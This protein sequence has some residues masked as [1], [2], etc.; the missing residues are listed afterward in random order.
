M[1]EH[2]FK[3]IILKILGKFIE[4]FDYNELKV[5][6]WNGHVT[7]HH[8]SLKPEALRF[9]SLASG[10][11][12]TVVK[13]V[14]GRLYLNLNWARLWSE[15]ITLTLEDV[16]LVVCPCSEFDA[17][18][19][20]DTNRSKKRTKLLDLLKK[21]NYSSMTMGYFK[22]LERTIA[23]NLLL[24]IKHLHIRYEDTISN[25]S[26]P[27]ALG[28]TL[29]KLTY[30]PCDAHWLQSFIT[31]E[32]KMQSQKSFMKLM[33]SSVAVYHESR[34]VRLL[35]DKR[36]WLNSVGQQEFLE[37]MGSYIATS[38]YSPMVSEFYILRPV[39]AE[40]RIRRSL[41]S[42]LE[43]EI[44]KTSVNILI[45]E[46]R[47]S[48][49]ASQYQD[50]L[51]IGSFVS[52][53]RT[54]GKYGEIRPKVR[55]LE[56]PSAWWAYAIE[57]VG[58]KLRR[59][60]E[61]RRWSYLDTRR[62][63]KQRYI[64]VYCTLSITDFT[65]QTGKVFNVSKSPEL[66]HLTTEQL[67]I[68]L[69]E[70]ED[71]LSLEEIFVFRIL[72]ER[73]L[74]TQAESSTSAKKKGWWGFGWLLSSKVSPEEEAFIKSL[75]KYSEMFA[76][77]DEAPQAYVKSFMNFE[78]RSCTVSLAGR[79]FTG[80]KAALLR[81]HIDRVILQRQITPG[82][83]QT[84]LALSSFDVTDPF[85]PCKKFSQLLKPVNSE[86]TFYE[87][88]EA[89]AESFP[90][91][92]DGFQA[93][94]EAEF[95]SPPV[96]L[97]N[98]EKGASLKLKVNV[99]TTE[100]LYNRLCLERIK[101]FFRS[102]EAL[103]FYKLI[104]LQAINQISSIKHRTQAKLE[105]I[106]KHHIDLQLDLRMSA[107]I[108]TVP[109]NP[110]SEDSA[111]LVIDFGLLRVTS[112]T[113]Q[114][115]SV[116]KFSSDFDI[117]EFYDLYNVDISDL[118]VTLISPE[119]G[120]N[121]AL[122]DKFSIRMALEK[123]I[124]PLDPNYTTVK[125][126][127][128]IS[129]LKARMSKVQFSMLKQ[130]QGEESPANSSSI[131][132]ASMD[133]FL[134][135]VRDDAADD[136][137]D[138]FF[139]ADEG[140]PTEAPT[141]SIKLSVAPDKEHLSLLFN[142][143]EMQL[144]LLSDEH[145]EI[146]TIDSH[147]YGVDT[148]VCIIESRKVFR[149]KLRR[150]VIRDIL[151][152]VLVDSDELSDLV[153]VD[154][155][156]FEGE[157]LLLA[158]VSHLQMQY[159]DEPIKWLLN[160]AKPDRKYFKKVDF[161][162]PKK[163]HAELKFFDIRARVNH[164]NSPLTEVNVSR[165]TATL[166][167]HVTSMLF[168]QVGAVEGIDFLT[169]TPFF[170]T[171][172]SD[173]LTLKHWSDSGTIVELYACKI[174][175]L[176]EMVRQLYVFVLESAPVVFLQKLKKR[177]SQYIDDED[178]VHK[179]RFEFKAL[180]PVV[181]LVDAE[182]E[183]AF[184]LGEFTLI[185][186]N[187]VKTL[188]IYGTSVNVN[189]PNSSPLLCSFEL[190]AKI[191]KESAVAKL[192]R[193]A[194]AC[195]IEQVTMLSCIFKSYSEHFAQLSKILHSHQASVAA[196]SAEAP[197]VVHRGLSKIV[198]LEQI[199]VKFSLRLRSKSVELRW[200][201][202][203]R[204]VMRTEL[205]GI[206]LD[207]KQREGNQNWWKMS[208]QRIST[209]IERGVVNELILVHQL[210]KEDSAMLT[211]CKVSPTHLD[212]D[213]AYLRVIISPFA[214]VQLS[215]F[216]SEVKRLVK[217][218]PAR[219]SMTGSITKLQV[220][221]SEDQTYHIDE[222]DS[223][224]VHSSVAL[225]QKQLILIDLSAD[226][227]DKN[228]N[229][230]NLS[231]ALECNNFVDAGI[232]LQGRFIVQ[233]FKV[234][235][236]VDQTL[237]LLISKIEV[238]LSVEQI[239][240]I[241]TVF[242]GFKHFKQSSERSSVPCLNAVVQL[243]QLQI[244]ICADSQDL[245]QPA[246]LFFTLL[247]DEPT[248][249]FPSDPLGSVKLETHFVANYFNQQVCEWE[250]LIEQVRCK[251]SYSVEDPGIPIFSLKSYSQF[252]VNIS[253][254]MI[255]CLHQFLLACSDKDIGFMRPETGL[256]SRHRLMSMHSGLLLK[257]ETGQLLKYWVGLRSFS[258]F[259]NE[260]Q[261]LDF[262]NL[263]EQT[264]LMRSY[265]GQMKAKRDL[266][267]R[268]VALQVDELPRINGISLDK[269]GP[270]VYPMLFNGHELGLI[271][272]LKLRQGDKVMTVRSPIE[273]RNNLSIPIEVLLT[274]PLHQKGYKEECTE[275][276]AV[277]P[278]SSAPVPITIAL[279][280]SIKVR[281]H[282][283]D[284]SQ[285]IANPPDTPLQVLCPVK[286][287]GSSVSRKESGFNSCTI[288]M[289]VREQPLDNIVVR[290]YEFDSSFTLQ[291]LLCTPLDFAIHRHNLSISDPILSIP[292]QQMQK[293]DLDDNLTYG[294]CVISQ[295]DK[296][297]SYES[298]EV[299]AI[300]VVSLA[301]K[302]PGYEW[303][304]PMILLEHLGTTIFQF[305]K[306]NSEQIN[307]FLE[308]DRR[309]GSVKISA[310]SQFWLENHTSLPIMFQHSED[311][312]TNVPIFLPY[313]LDDFLIEGQKIK[314]LEDMC[315]TTAFDSSLK[316]KAKH[317]KPWLQHALTKKPGFAS[318]SAAPVDLAQS[319]GLLTKMFSTRCDFNFAPQASIRVANSD[320]S[321]HF[322]LIAVEPDSRMLLNSSSVKA[323]EPSISGKAGCIYEI[324]MSLH[325][326]EAPFERT[327]LIKFMP[328]FVLANRLP[329]ELLI[330]Q[331][332]PTSDTDGVC[333]L[334][335]LETTHFHWPDASRY[336]SLCVKL[337]D[338]GW[339]WSGSFNIDKADDFF[340][341]IRNRHSHL[342]AILQVTVTQ[343]G[344]TFQVVFADAS[345][346][347]PY[348][349]E[350]LSMENLLIY[351]TDVREYAKIISP[352]EITSYAW[353]EPMLPK[354][355][356][357]VVAGASAKSNINLGAYK[358]DNPSS[359]GP[360]PL[361]KHGNH[362]SHALYIEITVE[363]SCKVLKVRHEQSEEEYKQHKRLMKPKGNFMFRCKFEHLGVSLLDMQPQELLYVSLEHLETNFE[364]IQYDTKF[365]LKFLSFQIDN[366]LTNSQF[367]VVLRP[368]SEVAD[369][370]MF[371]F[372][373]HMR[374]NN[375]EDVTYFKQI[376][377]SPAHVNMSIEGALIERLL[378]FSGEVSEIMRE[379]RS[380]QWL[381]ESE[382]AKKKERKYYF[383][384]LV[385]S[386]LRINLSLSSVPSMFNQ[387]SLSPLR[388]LL[389]IIANVGNVFLDF[390]VFTLQHR[391]YS[392]DKLRRELAGYYTNGC[393]SQLL[394]IILSSDILGN[395]YELMRQLQIG[396]RDLVTNTSQ[397]TF[398]GFAE[399]IS[400]LV[401]H[402]AYGASNS[403]SRFLDSLHKGIQSLYQDEQPEQ[404]RRWSIVLALLR[405]ALLVPNIVVSI[406]SSTA[407][408]V[409]DAIHK[410]P[411]GF[412]K[413][414]PRCLLASR[415][416]TTYSYD[417]SL[418]QYILA[419]V[420][421]GQYLREELKHHFALSEQSVLI[422]S[423][424]VLGAVIDRVKPEWETELAQ[425]THLKLEG[426]KLVIFYFE[427]LKEVGMTV[428]T[429]AVT[430]D[431]ASLRQ[432]KEAL[433]EYTPPQVGN[434]ASLS[435][436]FCL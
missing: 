131:S 226:F 122:V 211:V 38:L 148:Q 376:V 169:R 60:I 153:T 157:S 20:R 296:G 268:S 339:Q 284:W 95:A 78:L 261:L 319:S 293:Y 203:S 397:A 388:V 249:T 24:S 265:R 273:I 350:N 243:Q 312:F 308:S 207:F 380:T 178:D 420:H 117:S 41:L 6:S 9:L 336:Q 135:P 432:L 301:L 325:V 307:V 302:L 132:L 411:V 329:F 274:L 412:R 91:A 406:A 150:V 433:E 225:D 242:K 106:M 139:D 285:R 27:F 282:G 103:E 223:L 344:S 90:D 163:L 246:E 401:K 121:W 33:I 67:D 159:Y 379:V 345:V 400:S 303:S 365:D 278:H 53:H 179:H 210:C 394:S 26:Q 269:Q 334:Q 49:E 367:P 409:R 220:C 321:E 314:D 402:T 382:G 21:S 52:T 427:D 428:K 425:I 322:N 56:S 290:V 434:R 209:L 221:I 87:I 404:Q 72:A 399:G 167:K 391:Q 311:R 141:P 212:I 76:D 155:T 197:Q 405:T 190:E 174:T 373:L 342:E 12:M 330:T 381:K 202:E 110:L 177:R 161:K 396:V 118:S 165:L 55:P 435:S 291:N 81:V 4:D 414:P 374:E 237:Q 348:R 375:A 35:T 63:L 347:P 107:P 248:L 366:Q 195:S 82:Y 264:S 359:Y 134:V 341:R 333:R 114:F 5:D 244:S 292:E 152:R 43:S 151:S 403:T 407:G 187:E 320:W 234:V 70:L 40:I 176:M 253:T 154:F 256:P 430:G 423:K 232:D 230:S 149:T 130:L 419:T 260:E 183:V 281:V 431:E 158:S 371:S 23:D 172:G 143:E 245:R 170:S 193:A 115:P 229:I 206:D 386:N 410:Q 395:P 62:A 124:L 332:E 129:S 116:R 272:S 418:G 185:D 142:I 219:M 140:S 127:G 45:D 36:G 171:T 283:F 258:V 328:R 267:N 368:H 104:E 44:P 39:N 217:A 343:E 316:T 66:A 383:D 156:A 46:M 192:N 299:S 191:S 182:K 270:T 240:L 214:L 408:H 175:A 18:L 393:K 14:I 42:P 88:D 61:K 349:I 28:F 199:P 413:R 327:K 125:V 77:V 189:L 338:H 255:S 241:Q 266:R 113:K 416:L 213:L 201:L 236:Q 250:P 421:Q 164:D 415:M 94:G 200:I 22:K 297:E 417:E 32:S 358:L 31:L 64:E 3:A 184:D 57:A 111:L 317:S 228:W 364:R 101:N 222:E 326:P 315:I 353:D 289:N 147:V 198:K 136:E 324:A 309:S 287:W 392:A 304:R 83:S 97:L 298:I 235:S 294:D 306:R 133:E 310:Y 426:Y 16:Q 137:E 10:L 102:P 286:K 280:Q 424:R 166:D 15:P 354:T 251:L 288:V 369:L 48:L 86:E 123:C 1:F 188:S 370:R 8:V 204:Q 144:Q 436:V 98:M 275:V 34:P 54:L 385:I 92:N 429:E 390:P 331:F 75:E 168:V 120:E 85:T 372:K 162:A 384:K 99:E 160:L 59:R 68:I 279:F 263:D 356:K 119:R 323:Y 17:T 340:L 352:F 138:I 181:S 128:S 73:N 218:Q 233:P 51:M 96:L 84:Y 37:T 305:S 74:Y 363:G 271:C 239:M 300:E 360:I 257:N 89:E 224:D 361:K 50:L 231:V 346:L 47:I 19:A 71:R 276:V 295:L 208:M 238:D 216:N 112:D 79:Q 7:Q 29:E 108:V 180:H 109:L 277:E 196:I 186:D 254:A 93:F 318:L 247:L 105:Y 262:S 80:L 227:E 215:Q 335:P 252:N 259:P 58:L 145:D 126:R 362:P 69:L 146:A 337:E 378:L 205:E 398:S 13:G 351:Q 30:H 387:Y 11:N 173:L 2:R 389:I 100:L 357:V 25:P 194:L 422:T 377:I 313:H 355:L 65:N